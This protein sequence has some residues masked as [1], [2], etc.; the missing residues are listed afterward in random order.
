MS[1]IAETNEVYF[2]GSESLADIVD[3]MSAFA[4]VIGR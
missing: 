4:R 2:F 1:A 3:I